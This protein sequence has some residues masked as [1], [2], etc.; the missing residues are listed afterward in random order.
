MNAGCDVI[1]EKPM[2]TDAPQCL[3]I[4]ETC[5]RTGRRCRVA[6]NY[7]YS[8]PRAQV[9]D[10]LMRGEIGD[11]LSVDFHWLLN[12]HHGADYFRRWHSQKKISGGLFVHKSTHHFDLVNWWLGA[13]P[14]SVAATGTF[15]AIAA[16]PALPGATSTSAPSWMSFQASACSRPPLP[17]TSTR[18]DAGTVGLLRRRAGASESGAR[19]RIVVVPNLVAVRTLGPLRSVDYADDWEKW[20]GLSPPQN[21]EST[22]SEG[23]LVV[24]RR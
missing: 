5:R 16:V 23:V 20:R 17:T 3:Q 13:V 1:T 21:Q 15:S 9:K 10:L 12:T 8:P 2:T 24:I 19:R 14:V 4:L 18:R 22:S 6:F 11:V 7:R